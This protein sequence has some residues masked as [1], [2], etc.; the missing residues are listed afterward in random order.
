M[1]R[2]LYT[3]LALLSLILPVTAGAEAKFSVIPPR[4]VIAGNKFSV[5]FRLE[6]G[7]GNGIKVSE[8][9]G[10]TFLYGPSTS[11]SSSFQVINGRTSSSTTVDYSYIYRADSEGTFTIPSASIQVDG[12]TLR[13]E[14]VSFKVLPPDQ[15][16]AGSQGVRVDDLS[17]QTSDKQVGRDEVFVRMIPSRTSVYEQEPVECTIK[18]YTKYQINRFS[19]VSQPNFDGCLIEEIPIQSALNE[20]EHYNGENYMTAILKKVILF[21]QKSGK[22]TFNS[23]KYDISV[24]QY[25]KVNRG[26]FTSSLPVEKEIHVNP[27]D[28]SITVQPLP[29]PQPEGFTGAVGTF[30]ISSK[31]S[32]DNLRTNEA[33]SLTYTI[34]GTGNIR[35]I[36]EPKPEFPDEFEQYSPRSETDAHVAGNNVTGRMTIEYTFVPQAPGEYTIPA[37]DFVY[38]DPSKKEYITLPLPSRKINVARGAGVT[39]TVTAE[40]R[41]IN[42]GMTD[43][44]HI[45]PNVNDMSAS[46]SLIVYSWIY[47]IIWLALA[48]ALIYIIIWRNHLE[49]RNADVAGLRLARAGKLARKRLKAAREALVQPTGSDKF[50]EEILKALWG[51]LSDKLGIPSSQLTRDNIAARLNEKGISESLKD[52]VIE[53]LDECEM[54][55]YTPQASS[56]ENMDRVLDDT[57]K[58]MN[59]IERSK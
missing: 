12:K 9:N 49:K 46:H 33:A 32:N 31:L 41:D 58:L 56:R 21:P 50:Y 29:F 11:T 34:S 7:E 10:C 2:L 47:W 52:K 25:E 6:N 3:F 37:E 39:T 36:K 14:P 45:K 42:A 16:S 19:A 57:E 44:L 55:R 59:G 8:I 13:T 20:I 23:G 30:S 18:L 4:Q 1:N 26:F 27:G 43:I 38:F 54:A 22:L 53:I 40:K 48:L 51:Y 35:Y 5:T 24:V 17:T 28:L 15:S